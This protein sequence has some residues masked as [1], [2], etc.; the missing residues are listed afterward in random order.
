MTP[1]DRYR[2][3]YEPLS[4]EFFIITDL[5]ELGRQKGLEGFLRK[6]FPVLATG[7]HYVVFDLNADREQAY[8]ND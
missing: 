8:E 5:D 2:L 6:R 7:H 4:P 1:G 3:H